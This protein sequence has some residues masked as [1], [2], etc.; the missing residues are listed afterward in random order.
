MEKRVSPILLLQRQKKEKDVKLKSILIL[1]LL[2]GC[3]L[4]TRLTIK[5]RT[6]VSGK[7]HICL[8]FLLFLVD[9]NGIVCLFINTLKK[10][11]LCKLTEDCETLVDL[12]ENYTVWK[13]L[14]CLQEVGKNSVKLTSHYLKQWL[15][16]TDCCFHKITYQG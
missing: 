3:F 2:M 6:Q 10:I 13:T 12:A 14:K 5:H 16:K 8:S 1:A 9:I 4:I 7:G 15:V 11:W